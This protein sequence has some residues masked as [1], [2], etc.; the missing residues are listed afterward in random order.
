MRMES[1]D[2]SKDVVLTVVVSRQP[3]RVQSEPRLV[4]Y[5]CTSLLSLH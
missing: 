2:A 1:D 4:S 5:S 3:E